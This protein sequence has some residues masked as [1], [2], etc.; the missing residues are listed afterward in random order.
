MMKITLSLKNMLGVLCLCFLYNCNSTSSIIAEEPMTYQVFYD[1]LSPYGTWINYPEYGQVWNPNTSDDFSPYLTNGHWTATT[2]GWTW[3]SGYRWGWAP[4]HYGRWHYDGRFGW[5]WIPGYEWSPAWVVWGTAD[6]YYCWAPLMPNVNV[7]VVFNSWSPTLF[8]WNMCLRRHIINNN[9]HQVVI[10]GDRARTGTRINTIP[11]YQTTTAHHLYYASG[12]T[13]EEVE[14]ETK[15]RITPVPIEEM[16]KL[17][18][19]KNQ[20]RVTMYRPTIETP[21]TQQSRTQKPSPRV[22]RNAVAPSQSSAPAIQDYPDRQRKEQRT[23]IRNLPQERT[24][25]RH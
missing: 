15:G 17:P 13:F 11:N 2:A 9:L 1:N 18:N 4:F 19:R 5:L 14:R 21:D 20:A 25:T 16:Q 8:Y 3:V 10:R 23:N 22:Y 7:T 6:D 12:P 24:T